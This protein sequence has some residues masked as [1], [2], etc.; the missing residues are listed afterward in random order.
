MQWKV[1]LSIGSASFIAGDV[2]YAYWFERHRQVKMYASLLRGEGPLPPDFVERKDTKKRLLDVMMS[3]ISAYEIIVGNHGTGK[4]TLVR[5]V[6]REN[7]GIIYVSIQRIQDTSMYTSLIE[8]FVTAVSWEEPR[9][10][11]SLVLLGK[12]ISVPSK[13]NCIS[14]VPKLM[15][16]YWCSILTSP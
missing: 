8:S 9:L 16:H 6:A 4:T 12:L 7:T 3:P 15:F 13:H 1:L 2:G 11:W 5:E 14:Y 10:L